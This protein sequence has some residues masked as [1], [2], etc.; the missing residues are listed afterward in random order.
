[1]KG[2]LRLT[3]CDRRFAIELNRKDAEVT[4][5]AL[6]LFLCES[7]NLN[8]SLRNNSLNLSPLSQ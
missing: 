1:M 6:R 2:D 3:I 5:S 8:R 4:Q 7:Q